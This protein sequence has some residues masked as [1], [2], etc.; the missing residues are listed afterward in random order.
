MNDVVDAPRSKAAAFGG[1]LY[2][3]PHDW[4]AG[5]WLGEFG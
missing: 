5:K 3:S 1:S 2:P 4:W